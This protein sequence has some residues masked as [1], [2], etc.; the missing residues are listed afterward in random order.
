MNFDKAFG[1]QYNIREMML[2]S[3][4]IVERRLSDL[5]S[6]FADSTA[7]AAALEE[8]DPVIYRVYGASAASGE[9]DLHYGL[10]VLMPGRVGEEF[11]L[12]KGHIHEWREAA[13]VY[14]GLAGRGLMLL[15]DIRT[16]ESETYPLGENRIVYVPGNTAH[17]TINTGEDP[18]VYI[19]VY[20]AAAGHDYGYLTEKNFRK[21][22]VKTAS[23]HT[24]RDREDY[25]KDLETDA[26]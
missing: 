10:G 13:E 20:P 17:R 25:L 12:T 4:E 18:L 16:G 22:V 14:I 2:E 24:L 7:Y 26:V 21:V 15:E 9:G 6:A 3:D 8:G 11:H 23:G 5:N 19:G 1:R